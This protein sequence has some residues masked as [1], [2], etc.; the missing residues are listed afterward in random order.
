MASRWSGVT[1]DCVDP[2]R[3]STFWATLLGIPVS[4]E[5]GGDPAWATVGSR[6]GQFP[7]LTFQRVAE[8]KAGKVRIHLDVEVDDI[9][10]GRHQVEEL[11]GRFSGFRHDYDEG[12]VLNMLDPE[13]HEFCLVQYFDRAAPRR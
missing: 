5:H 3:L 2:V 8:P 7:R 9:D 4:S 1:I 13:G 6:A 12:V 10:A 11:G